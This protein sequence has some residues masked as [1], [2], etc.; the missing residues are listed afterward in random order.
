VQPKSS[1][2]TGSA[3]NLLQPKPVRDL[4]KRL[5]RA[6]AETEPQAGAGLTAAELARI[7]YGLAEHEEPTDSQLSS[8]RRAVA[9]L[10]REG[11]A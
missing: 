8:V 11:L 5:A 2:A 7:G 4:T 3:Q 1:V 9:R 6:L 10:L